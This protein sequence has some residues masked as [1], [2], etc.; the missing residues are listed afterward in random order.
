MSFGTNTR[1]KWFQ[2]AT[3]PIAICASAFQ[4]V[5]INAGPTAS[6]V[7][8]TNVSSTSSNSSQNSTTSITSLP[9]MTSSISHAA[10]ASC[11]R[12]E[13]RQ[14]TLLSV[15]AC[16]LLKCRPNTYHCYSNA[17]YRG[18]VMN[19]LI[20]MSTL[21]MSDAKKSFSTFTKNIPAGALPSQQQSSPTVRAA[22]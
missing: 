18:S 4:K 16:T 6:Q 14:L 7:T 3:R 5:R 21:S 11:A 19:H 17:S 15:T 22:P 8:Y 2:T 20:S 13:A 12:V 1:K 9:F 10:G